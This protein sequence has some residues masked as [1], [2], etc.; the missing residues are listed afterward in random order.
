MA[1]VGTKATNSV[2]HILTAPSGLPFTVSAISERESA[3]LA[4]I[5][6]DQVVAQNV[7]FDLAERSA[8]VNYP[9]V[10]VYCE[11]MT[12]L[13]KEKFRTFSGKVSMV[14]EVRVS[15]DR[16][17]TLAQEIQLYAGAVTEVLD[18]HRGEWGPGMFY[19]GGYKVEF[20]PAKG[21]RNN[22]S[23]PLIR[24]QTI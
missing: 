13:L 7:A 10:Y 9:T 4:Q 6:F 23:S 17:E 14:V 20:G 24:T 16:L 12:N 22:N 21:P 8:G 3:Q 1:A 2:L 19:T 11:G 18:S 5:G 15:A